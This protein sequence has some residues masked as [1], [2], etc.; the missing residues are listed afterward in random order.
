MWTMRSGLWV[1]MWM[2]LV[3]GAWAQERGLDYN[4]VRLQADAVAEVPNDQMLVTLAVEHQ[5][6]SAADLP[7]LVNA[8]M[9][10]ALGIAKKQPAVR[11]QTGEYT[12][13]PE[14]ASTRIVGW[15]A[16]QYLL[17][18]GEDF[19]AVAALVTAL[20]EKLQV[21]GMQFQPTR[22]TRERVEAEL[23]QAALKAFAAKAQLIAETMDAKGYEVVEINVG[24]GAQPVYKSRARG[25]EMMAMA[26]DAAPPVA[27]EGGTVTLTVTAGGQIQLR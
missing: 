25:M 18:E 1:A 6:R 17:L 9:G 26:A 4:L 21:K 14:Y 10:W 12:T 13:Q 5:S 27:V 19:D 23:T 3:P 22:A 20:Q 8:D 24:G 7:A 11:A 15:R 2:L 16:Q